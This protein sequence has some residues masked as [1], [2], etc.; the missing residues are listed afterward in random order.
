MGRTSLMH[1]RGPS[2]ALWLG[3]AVA[4]RPINMAPAVVVFA[5][6]WWR[7]GRKPAVALR[8]AIPLVVIG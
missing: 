5:W 7:T 2:L 1:R 6:E 3:L 8:F 4:C